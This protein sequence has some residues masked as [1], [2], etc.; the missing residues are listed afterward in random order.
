MI[1][2]IFQ[3][4]HRY[5]G[6]PG[7]NSLQGLDANTEQVLD[8]VEQALEHLRERKV[9]AQCLIREPQGRFAQ[10]LAVNRHIPGL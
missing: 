9:R 10:L 7:F 1:F 5:L 3:R 6:V 2:G 8:Q 4:I